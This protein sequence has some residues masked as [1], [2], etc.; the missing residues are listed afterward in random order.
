MKKTSIVLL[1][2]VLAQSINARDINDIL[3]LRETKINFY[4]PIHSITDFAVIQMKFGS[5]DIVFQSNV[6]KLRKG[7]IFRVDL[8]YSNYPKGDSLQDLTK[9]RIQKILELRGDLVSNESIQWRLCRQMGLTDESDAML[10]FHGA[11]IYYKP[12]Q[13]PTLYRME[14]ISLAEGLPKDKAPI[15]TNKTF[16]DFRD[17]SVVA[18]LRRN[19]E[20]QNSTVVI[21]VTGSMS[22]YILQTVYWFLYKYSGKEKINLVLFNDGDEIADELKRIGRTGGIYYKTAT[23]YHDFR[24]LVI[25]ATSKGCGGDSPENDLEAVL[26]AQELFPNSSEI[27]L[28]ADNTSSIRDFRLLDRIKIPVRTVLCGTHFSINEQYLH[29]AYATN[30]SVHTIKT[31]LK[32]LAQVKEGKTIEIDGKTYKLKDGEFVK[33][34]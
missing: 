30:G 32:N 13:D 8:I 15:I 25:Q 26:K 22:P 4:R 11:V 24:D 2:I 14:Q 20:W 29:L 18:A 33:I 12:E 1:F 5:S 31:D 21:D 9:R 28:I 10:L 16:K 17:T 19:K 23:D 27:I 7:K 3:Q 34:R 6:A